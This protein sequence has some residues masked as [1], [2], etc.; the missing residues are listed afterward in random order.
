[1]VQFGISTHLFANRPLSAKHLELIKE[2]GFD[3]I[4]LWAMSPHLDYLNETFMRRLAGVI[5][6]IGLRVVSFHGPF[7]LRFEDSN[8]VSLSLG[9]SNKIWRKRLLDQLRTLMDF[10]GMFGA[11]TIVTHG[12][13]ET[14]VEEDPEL[15]KR[16][17][18]ESL[19]ELAPYAEARGIRVVVENIFTRYS[20]TISLR[21]HVEQLRS[22][23]LGIC[24]DTGHANLSENPE[25]AVENCGRR[26][27]HVHFS[28]NHGTQDEHLVPYEGTIDWRGVCRNLAKCANL[29]HAVLELMFER[30][31]HQFDVGHVRALLARAREGVDH[32]RAEVERATAA[33]AKPAGS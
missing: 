30:E 11:D 25:K 28:D 6:G 27:Y 13:G 20:R 18:R 29:R 24:L 3:A 23:S 33:L 17:F 22:P 26:L 32:V 21:K 12:L 31:E 14:E 15:G 1:M 5:E 19:A 9:D 8:F 2:Y 7:F 16:L 4:E 10:M